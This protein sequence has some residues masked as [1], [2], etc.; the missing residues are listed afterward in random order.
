MVCDFFVSHFFFI[1]KIE[2]G[3]LKIPPHLDTCQ[4]LHRSF[5]TQ[6]Q[7]H[8]NEVKNSDSVPKAKADSQEDQIRK[9]AIV[10]KIAS[11]IITS[12]PK[13]PV[14]IFLFNFPYTS[15]KVCSFLLKLSL[16]NLIGFFCL[17]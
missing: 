11:Y 15:K 3:K 12:L 5:F 7:T 8:T 1:N 14:K 4:I 13:I 9:C 17:F 10:L 16:I 6:T 2:V